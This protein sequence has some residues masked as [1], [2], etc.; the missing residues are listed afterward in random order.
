MGMTD[1]LQ[2]PFKSD[3]E[4]LITEAAQLGVTVTGGGFRTRQQ[5]IALRISHCGSS[6]YDIY[7]KPSSQCS[8]PTAIPGTSMHEVGWA[9]DFTNTDTIIGMVESLAPKY[10][11]HRTVPGERWH[12]EPTYPHSNAAGTTTAAADPAGATATGTATTTTSRSGLG[13]AVAAL[14]DPSTWRR[15]GLIL[16]G[17]LLVL[18]GAWLVLGD[19]APVTPK[20]LTNL[21]KGA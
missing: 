12:Y 4:A 14:L 18:V 20:T 15:L 6:Q 7:Q 5:Q 10:R 21:T 19:A 11:M 9:F 8:P 17:V 16:G 1:G 3:V 13:G 2:E